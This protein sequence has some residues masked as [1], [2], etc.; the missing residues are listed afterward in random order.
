MS[1]HFR[2]ALAQITSTDNLQRNLKIVL[3]AYRIA[4]RETGENEPAEL[5]V[6][7]ENT[8]FLKIRSGDTLQA[9]DLDGPELG[10][11]SAKVNVA[12]IPILLTTALKRSDG[13][14]DNATLLFRPDQAP[15]VVYRK[16]HLF[17]VDVPGAPPVKESDTFAPGT[18]PALIEI[19]SWKFGLAIC[20][21]LRF[22]ELFLRYA[23][24]ADVILVP[25]AFLV[26]T[27]QAHWEVLLRARAIE[28]QCFVAAPA[29]SGSH[30]STT[31]PDAEPRLTFGHTLIVD[32]WGKIL[33]QV[34]GS[35][36]VSMVT[37]DRTTLSR[38]RAQIP[39][40]EHRRLN[41]L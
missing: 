21:D 15:E 1:A 11:I 7:P 20:Y 18:A 34:T 27:G 13:R 16:I 22:A 37:L 10:A 19:N 2:L 9:P 8:L 28:S 4:L 35:P 3:D 23:Q 12:K 31:N 36:E 25:S 6:F 29:Q 5:V 24:R 39:M 17:D 32:P 33:D 30:V 14:F 38:V 40:K 26:P 41:P